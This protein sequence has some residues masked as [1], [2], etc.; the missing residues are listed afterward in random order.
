MPTALIIVCPDMLTSQLEYS[1]TASLKACPKNIGAIIF[2]QN[3]TSA[4]YPTINCVNHC[5]MPII[6]AVVVPRT[7]DERSFCRVFV[8]RAMSAMT[9]KSGIVVARK[10]TFRIPHDVFSAHPREMIFNNNSV[11]RPIACTVVLMCKF[12]LIIPSYAHRSVRISIKTLPDATSISGAMLS[13]DCIG[14]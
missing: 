7:N 9:K 5:M 10:R 12:F 8:A 6:P 2:P 3:F 11:V 1:I 4:S 13:A 14:R